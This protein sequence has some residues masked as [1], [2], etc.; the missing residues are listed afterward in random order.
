LRE[1]FRAKVKVDNRLQSIENKNN[2][3]V[4]L[5][6]GYSLIQSVNQLGY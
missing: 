3:L 6:F 1:N 5:L 2:K 4:G